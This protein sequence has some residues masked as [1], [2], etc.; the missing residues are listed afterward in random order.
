[1]TELQKKIA[2]ETRPGTR[3]V[4]YIHKFRSWTPTQERG[5]VRLYVV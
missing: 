4:S 1:M 3:V 5:N 2:R